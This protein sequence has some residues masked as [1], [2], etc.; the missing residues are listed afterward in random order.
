MLE[1]LEPKV[2]SIDPKARENAKRLRD[3]TYNIISLGFIQQDGAKAVEQYFKKVGPKNYETEVYMQLGKAYLGK[4]LFRN[5]ADSFD[6]FVAKYPFNARAPEFSSAAI[7]A[8]Q[9][10][11]FPSEVLPAKE[12][13]VQ[14][15][16]RQ[17]EFWAKADESTREN[18]LPFLQSHVMDLAKHWHANAQQSKKDEDY[19]KAAKWYREYLTLNPPELEAVTINQLLAEALFAAKQF[20]DAIVEF[21]KTAY[22]YQRNPRANEAAYFALLAYNE[23]EQ[24]GLKGTQ[25]EQDAWWARR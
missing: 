21:E 1:E 22:G 25:E 16:N 13:F 6:F 5:A 3:D 4:R 17:S 2:K 18:L 23:Q 19:L 7:K 20:D 12:K 10:G 9:D 14:R 24:A 15:Y 11:G 8:Y